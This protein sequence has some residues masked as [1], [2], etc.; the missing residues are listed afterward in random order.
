MVFT[1]EQGRV[2]AGTGTRTDIGF[3]H[4]EFEDADAF[5]E[6]FA[7]RR[8]LGPVKLRISSRLAFHV[9]LFVLFLRRQRKLEYLSLNQ[10]W[11]IPLVDDIY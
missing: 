7:A 11:R 2:L 4:C 3:D 8:D 5:V 1:A 6:T 9:E 10:I